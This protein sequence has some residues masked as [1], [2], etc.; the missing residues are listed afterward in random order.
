MGVEYSTHV[1]D[2]KYMKF[3]SQNLGGKR[4]LVR[5]RYGWDDIKLNFKE[6]GCGFLEPF[7]V[8]QE[9]DQF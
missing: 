5:P 1:T 2:E 7:R 8:V 3:Q 9:R 6:M 4:P